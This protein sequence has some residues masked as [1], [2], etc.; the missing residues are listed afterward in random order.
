M[1][2]TFI[3]LLLIAL[4]IT[5][6]GA[7]SAHPDRA[8]GKKP[9]MASVA[10]RVA[11]GRITSRSCPYKC[12]IVGIPKNVCRDWREGNTCYIEDLR[13]PPDRVYRPRYYQHG[14][15][16]RSKVPPPRVEIDR[17][18]SGGR[19]Y[20]DSRIRIRG[21]VEGECLTEAGLFEHGRKVV[22]I[23]VA[24][25]PGFRRFEFE[26]DSRERRDPEIRVYNVQGERD[27]YNVDYGRD[28]YGEDRD[29]KRG[30]YGG[31]IWDILP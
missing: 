21:S 27:V 7:L 3:I 15:S 10:D 14:C 25:E 28:R 24:L 30:R 9:A 4:S 2:R 20:D 16:Q 5:L 18:K 6:P 22:D 19:Y 1:R 31:S 12:S 11:G 13:Y 23:P 29:Y 26:V 17:V 8:K